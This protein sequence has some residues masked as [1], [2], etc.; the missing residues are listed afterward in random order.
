MKYVALSPPAKE[1]DIL[2]HRRARRRG[3][4]MAARGAGAAAP[5]AGGRLA[6]LSR[7]GVTKGSM[8]GRTLPSKFALA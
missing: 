8:T 4:I 5:D 6:Q 7:G 2:A 3:G 1:E